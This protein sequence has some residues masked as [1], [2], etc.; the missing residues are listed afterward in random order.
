[1]Q[2]EEGAAPMIAH[3]RRSEQS[4]ELAEFVNALR[5]V[6]RLESLYD[7]RDGAYSSDRVPTAEEQ[8]MRRFYVAPQRWCWDEHGARRGGA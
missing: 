6:L 8:E 4:A 3:G 1:M 7:D 2:G 5:E